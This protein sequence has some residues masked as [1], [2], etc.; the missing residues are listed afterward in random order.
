MQ[1]KSRVCLKHRAPKC[2]TYSLTI[3]GEPAYEMYLFLLDYK[4]KLDKENNAN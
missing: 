1:G 4:K 3:H 2:K